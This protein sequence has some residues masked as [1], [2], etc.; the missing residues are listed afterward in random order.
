MSVPE[1]SSNRSRR[2]DESAAL[3]ENSGVRE[4]AAG[5]VDSGGATGVEGKTGEAGVAG[6]TATL[7][8]AAIAGAAGAAATAGSVGMNEPAWRGAGSDATAISTQCRVRSNGVVGRRRRN[9]RARVSSRVR[10][11]STPCVQR[12]PA[13]RRQAPDSSCGLS[14]SNE[15]ACSAGAVGEP[16]R[17]ATPERGGAGRAGRVCWR[18]SVASVWRGPTSTN[19]ASG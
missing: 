9:L 19:N 11:S 14:F 1:I 18:T 8:V 12:R 13:V 10:S 5:M 3:R 16:K 2:R 6:A 7:A 15:T 17:P 4:K